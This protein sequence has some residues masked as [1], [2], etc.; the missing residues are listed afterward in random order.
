MNPYS[1]RPDLPFVNNYYVIKMIPNKI[2]ASNKR[3]T[4]T[5]I[6]ELRKK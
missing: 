3:E 5:C 6:T 4:K 2:A 1:S